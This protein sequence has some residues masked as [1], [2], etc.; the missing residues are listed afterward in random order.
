MWGTQIK[1]SRLAQQAAICRSRIALEPHQSEDMV[2]GKR[3][4]S[5]AYIT[6]GGI[7][8]D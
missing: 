7:D 4:L 1:E 6:L 2:A 8:G 5:E 3:Q